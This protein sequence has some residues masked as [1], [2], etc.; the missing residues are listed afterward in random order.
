MPFS[1]HVKLSANFSLG[2]VEVITASQDNGA[3]TIEEVWFS[4]ED[5]SEKLDVKP[6]ER[7]RIVPRQQCKSAWGHWACLRLHMI[8]QNWERPFIHEVIPIGMLINHGHHTSKFFSCM[9][10]PHR[11]IPILESCWPNMFKPQGTGCRIKEQFASSSNCSKAFDLV[12]KHFSGM[13]QSQVQQCRKVEDQ[14]WILDGLGWL[15][16]SEDDKWR[17]G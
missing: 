16:E 4:W 2:S 7:K 3:S 17:V 14:I 6:L 9:V 10:C 11:A 8:I 15:R 13:H 5:F 12:S 1:W